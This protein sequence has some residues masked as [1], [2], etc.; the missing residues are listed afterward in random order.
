ML[1]AL[2]SFCREQKEA[3][4]LREFSS[5]EPRLLEDLAEDILL[6]EREF[7]EAIQPKVKRWAEKLVKKNWHRSRETLKEILQK[8][9]EPDEQVPML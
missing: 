8:V 2:R 7:P 3:P 4:L 9:T 5:A 1:Q 6:I